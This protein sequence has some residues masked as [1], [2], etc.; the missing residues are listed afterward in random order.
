MTISHSFD[1]P[2]LPRAL[3]RSSDRPRGGH[4]LGKIRGNLLGKSGRTSPV[5][6]SIGLTSA[7]GPEN[8]LDVFVESTFWH[9]KPV[10]LSHDATAGLW[11][12]AAA[13]L[14]VRTPDV[15]PHWTRLVI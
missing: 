10:S 3:G 11:A 12:V 13:N 9:R 6:T 2:S 8:A 7:I 14:L 5:V 15:G 4:L 1:E